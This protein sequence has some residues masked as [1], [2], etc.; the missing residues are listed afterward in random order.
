MVSSVSASAQFS[1]S[2]MLGPFNPTVGRGEIYRNEVENHT[3]EQE[4]A[5][6]GKEKV[7]GKEC[8]WIEITTLKGEGP[9]RAGGAV[10][11]MGTR[12]LGERVRP[13]VLLCSHQPG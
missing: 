8:Y 7:D 2:D 5:M 3:I 13:G 4:Y 1:I 12:G 10:I 9:P 6:S 11:A